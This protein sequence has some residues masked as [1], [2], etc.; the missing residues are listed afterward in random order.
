MGK[1]FIYK[2][3]NSKETCMCIKVLAS[4]KMVFIADLF[5]Q[6]TDL[7]VAQS[8]C[9]DNRRLNLFNSCKAIQRKGII[10]LQ[11]VILPCD[12]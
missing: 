9:M 5:A 3:E 11:L 4:E 10:Q 1:L 8:S 7:E 12:H 6:P 2:R